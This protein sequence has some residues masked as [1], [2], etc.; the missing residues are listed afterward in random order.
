MELKDKIAVITGCSKGLGFE[1]TKQLL[2]KGA[3][4]YGLGI[5]NPEFGNENFHFIKC[6]VRNSEEVNNAFFQVYNESQN[7]I[8]I[9]INNAGLGYFGFIEN[10]PDNQIEEM[11]ETNLFGT[12]YTCRNAVGV[13]KENKSGHIINISSTAGLEGMHQVSVYCATKYAVRG[14]SDSLFKE[15]REYGVKVT[16]IFPG[17]VNTDFFR[18]APGI[19]AHDKMMSPIEVAFQI[20]N[21]LE[22]S[23]NFLFN[24]VVFRPLSV[25]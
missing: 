16:C 8:D 7:K 5:N 21:V 9:L 14:F 11:I 23:D 20:L 13:M 1:T 17:S 18:N 25:K 15:L 22:S 24:E 6:N 10:Y 19:K 2:E 3:V 4:V 12:I